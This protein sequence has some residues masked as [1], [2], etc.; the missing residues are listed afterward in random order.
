MSNAKNQSG[1]AGEELAS[2]YN[3]ARVLQYIYNCTQRY[4]AFSD[5]VWC[6]YVRNP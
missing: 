3:T 6:I 4:F 5:I 1:V 2:K